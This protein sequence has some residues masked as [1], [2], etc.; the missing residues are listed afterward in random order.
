EAGAEAERRCNAESGR[1]GQRPAAWNNIVAREALTAVTME[2]EQEKIEEYKRRLEEC[3]AEEDSKARLFDPKALA[4]NARKIQ[5]LNDKHL[6]IIRYGLL[7]TREFKALNLQ[8]IQDDEEKAYRVIHAMLQ[9]AQPDFTYEDFDGLPFDVKA[10]L[11]ERLSKVFPNFLPQQP[12]SG[13][14]PTRKP[15]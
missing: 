1:R 15:S 10:I 3:E 14:Q 7:T 5:T 11:T 2:T 13:S 9:K 4:L 8:G 12:Q 6:G